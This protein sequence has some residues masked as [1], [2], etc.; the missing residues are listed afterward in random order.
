MLYILSIMNNTELI[1][2]IS[3]NESTSISQKIIEHRRWIGTTRFNRG[4][5]GDRKLRIIDTIPPCNRNNCGLFLSGRCEPQGQTEICKRI[6]A[7]TLK[8]E[9]CIFERYQSLESDLDFLNLGIML[10]PLYVQLFVIQ[11]EIDSINSNPLT[12]QGTGSV[13][14]NPLLEHF[15]KIQREIRAY[16]ERL[17]A[18]ILKPK[19]KKVKS[20]RFGTASDYAGRMK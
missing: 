18:K 8:A 16:E 4:I 2:D 17:D 9:I 7:W 13:K 5:Y 20:Q 15:L 19:Q 1:Y 14:I 11:K 10:I 12:A 3:D 6:H